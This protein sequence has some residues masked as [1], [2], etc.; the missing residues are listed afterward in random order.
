VSKRMMVSAGNVTS[1]VERL[2]QIGYV[3]RGTD[4]NDRRSQLIRMTPKGRKHF[5][6]MA[7]A[8]QA[9]VAALLGGLS[10]Q[11]IDAAMAELAKVKESVVAEI[12]RNPTEDF[13]P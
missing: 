13:V 3:E 8:H 5:G 1:L 11:A 6:R 2:V 10:P 12:A 4:P 7:A 9:W